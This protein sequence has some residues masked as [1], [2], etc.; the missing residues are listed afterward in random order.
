VYG[1]F[2]WARRALSSQKRRFPARAD[3][4]ALRAPGPRQGVGAGRA[5]AVRERGR[6][7]PGRPG[8]VTRP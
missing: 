4:A 1:A 5:R 3:G 7:G 8:A 2:V 6:H